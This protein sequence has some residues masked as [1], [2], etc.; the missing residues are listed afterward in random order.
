MRFECRCTYHPQPFE[1]GDYLEGM[2]IDIV[3]RFGDFDSVVAGRIALDYYG[4]L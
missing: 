1:P 4:F 3:C 2:T